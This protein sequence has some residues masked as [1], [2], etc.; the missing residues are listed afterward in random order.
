MNL[1]IVDDHLLI[2]AGMKLPERQHLRSLE[3]EVFC[4][5]GPP[6]QCTRDARLRRCAGGHD[7]HSDHVRSELHERMVSGDGLPAVCKVYGDVVLPDRARCVVRGG[8]GG[9]SRTT[10]AAG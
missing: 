7:E 1:M 10:S 2:R 5:A 3:S 4:H 9:T 6:A 8:R